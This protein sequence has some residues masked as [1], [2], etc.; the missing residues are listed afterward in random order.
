MRIG[1]FGGTFN[2][3]HIG[4]MLLAREA[5]EKASIDRMIFMPCANPPHKPD[6]V[7]PDGEHRLNMVRLSVEGCPEFEVSDME[8]DAGGKSYTAKTLERLQAEYPND[9]LCFV[10]G[11]DS[12]CQMEGWF[13]PGEIFR[14]AE[15]VAAMRGGIKENQ[16][17]MAID[18]FK[19]KYDAQIT[20]VQMNVIEMSSSDIRNRINMGKSIKYMVCDSVIDYIEKNRIYEGCN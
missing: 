5:M 12:L 17:N 15:I 16:L 3:P 8:V 14:R 20:K 13:C 7:I 6:M 1:I 18:F 9:R 11:A 4:H 19:Q 10:V 2:P